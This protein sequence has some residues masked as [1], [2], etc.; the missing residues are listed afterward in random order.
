ML[1]KVATT[2][3]LDPGCVC[4]AVGNTDIEV[5]AILDLLLLGN[6]LEGKVWAISAE[7][8]EIHIAAGPFED[9]D[10]Q[11]R[12]PE[13]DGSVEVDGVVHDRRYP[14]FF[15]HASIIFYAAVICP[16]GGRRQVPR[17]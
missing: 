10:A 8:T 7:S 11:Y 14:Y 6:A 15:A 13:S 3:F 1:A 5:E 16:N 4:V 12:G 9:F 17:A 2:K